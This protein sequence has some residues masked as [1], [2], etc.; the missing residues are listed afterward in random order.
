ML[1]EAG[2]AIDQAVE[3]GAR[4]LLISGEG[5]AFSAGLDLQD[6]NERQM[7]G[8]Q[9]DVQSA[10]FMPFA[11]KLAG[12]PIPVIAAINGG[13]IGG[14]CAIALS[15]DIIIAGRSAFLQCPFV[16]L[17]LVPDT[18]ISWLIAQA[19]GRTR[20]MEIL[21]LGERIPAEE[22]LA[23]GLITQ[24]VRDEALL[25]TARDISLR[26]AEGP[27]VALGLIRKQV[28]K[29]LTLG[30]DDMLEVEHDHQQVAGATRDVKEGL[31]AFAERRS[32]VFSGK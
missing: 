5:R 22:A 30:F 31:A 28:M 7:Q 9:E 23:S 32:P 25:E 27:T 12:L 20:A 19:V 21:M 18:G 26:L 6:A 2:Q 8:N 1:T 15:A 4:A 29:A 11:R 16:K 14:G 24:I 13:A 3:Q 17:G 10:Y